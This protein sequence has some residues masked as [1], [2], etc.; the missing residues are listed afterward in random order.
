MAE[1]KDY[2]KEKLEH[3]DIKNTMLFHLLMQWKRWL[4][5]QGI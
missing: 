3:I 2:L 5:R 1:K 4:S